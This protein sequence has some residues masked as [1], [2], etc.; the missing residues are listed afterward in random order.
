MSCADVHHLPL[1][2]LQF[3]VETTS[4]LWCSDLWGLWMTCLTHFSAKICTMI[5]N[6]NQ[7]NKTET[8]SVFYYLTVMK[9]VKGLLMENLFLV[10]QYIYCNRN[11]IKL[12]TTFLVG[13]NLFTQRIITL[14][15]CSCL[16]VASSCTSISTL[17]SLHESKQHGLKDYVWPVKKTKLQELIKTAT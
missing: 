14:I 6:K 12:Q 8:G 4:V 15:C 13:M 11:D 2:F 9:P 1:P 5:K 7:C 3:V 10:I 17:H 16:P